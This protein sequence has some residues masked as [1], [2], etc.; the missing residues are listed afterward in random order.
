MSVTEV[1]ANAEGGMKIVARASSVVGGPPSN[2]VDRN[3]EARDAWE[4]QTPAFRRGNPFHPVPNTTFL[5]D[6]PPPFVHD[7]SGTME[8]V[9]N[10]A[11][12]E[13]FV[14]K[15][16]EIFLDIQGAGPPQADLDAESGRALVRSGQPLPSNANAD[17]RRGFIEQE[18]AKSP[19]VNTDFESGRAMAREGRELPANANA[20]VRRGHAEQRAATK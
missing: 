7:A 15:G 12:A 6:N 19:Q 8:I 5:S 14:A 13:L 3:L 9:I 20:D 1:T 11:G 17:V 16:S 10:R 2:P 4:A 18:K